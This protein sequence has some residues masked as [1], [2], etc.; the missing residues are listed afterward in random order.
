MYVCVHI[1]PYSM[2]AKSMEFRIRK[3]GFRSQGQ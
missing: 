3:P 2:V 1:W